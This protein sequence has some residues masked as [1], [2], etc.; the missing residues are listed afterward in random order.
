MYWNG[1]VIPDKMA[2]DPEPNW[3][4]L[5]LETKAALKAKMEEYVKY[6]GM[7]EDMRKQ[8][9]ELEIQLVVRDAYIDELQGKLLDWVDYTR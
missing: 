5:Y 3:R 8:C 7:Y 1:D 9:H 2:I 4:S 6:R